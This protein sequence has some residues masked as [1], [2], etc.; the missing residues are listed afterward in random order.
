[1]RFWIMGV[2]SNYKISDFLILWL[3]IY[4]L[5]YIFPFPLDYFPGMEAFVLKY[6]Y[7][8]R[9]TINLG[10]GIH[11]LGIADLQKIEITGS[12]D[13]TFDY[14]S[15]VTFSLLA[16]LM[17]IGVWMAYR[18]KLPVKKILAVIIIY[19]RYYVA[20]TLITYG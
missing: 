6:Y 10:V 3:C 5:I 4:M 19:A 1:M 13:T 17:A 16:L 7:A 12:G 14:V 18:S 20:I 15:L 11:V 9:D 8:L 2:F